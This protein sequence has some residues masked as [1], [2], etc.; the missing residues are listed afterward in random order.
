ME[1]VAVELRASN[2]LTRIEQNCF[3][4][5]RNDIDLNIKMMSKNKIM[6]NSNKYPIFYYV[7]YTT[8]LGGWTSISTIAFIEIIMI[9]K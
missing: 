1:N 4:N 7:I 6:I 5:V 3:E 2:I 8:R 9:G